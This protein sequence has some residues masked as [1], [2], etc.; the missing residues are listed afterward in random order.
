VVF[1]GAILYF[2]I[3]TIRRGGLKG[4]FFNANITRTLGEVDAVGPNL[5]SQRIKVHT[6]RRAS[7]S[8]VGVEVVSKS[9]GSYEMLPVVLSKDQAEQLASLLRQAVQDHDSL[10]A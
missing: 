8:L 10:V 3:N 7:E 4:A 6:L 2:G 1:A 5:V 9:I